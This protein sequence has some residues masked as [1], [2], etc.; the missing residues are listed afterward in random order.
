MSGVGIVLDMHRNVAICAGS[1]LSAGTPTHSSALPAI[2][3]Y[4]VSLL[5][6]LENTAEA[7]LRD[8]G[9]ETLFLK[10]AVL[11]PGKGARPT[12][13]RFLQLFPGYGFVG[14]DVASDPWHKIADVHGVYRLFKHGPTKPTPLASADIGR[15]RAMGDA[16]GV[17]Y[18]TA[19]KPIGV[20]SICRLTDDM[21]GNLTGI[22][23]WSDAARVRLLI[24]LLG[25]Q[26][27][28]T[29]P[30]SRVEVVG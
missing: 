26:V 1:V 6:N 14:F 8:L 11:V 15:L 9:F 24:S 17:L 29:V 21:Y 28:V 27:R 13:W 30:V 10:R 25:R 16:K 7:G 19:T 23:E 20:D 18:P 5:S 4:C 12:E 2:R 3:W 22:C